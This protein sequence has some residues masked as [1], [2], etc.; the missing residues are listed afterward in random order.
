MDMDMD[1]QLGFG[2]AA[3]I[4]TMDMHGCWNANKKLSLASLVFR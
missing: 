1:M 3:W 4:W 2:H